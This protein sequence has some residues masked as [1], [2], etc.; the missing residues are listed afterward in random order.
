[1][2]MEIRLDAKVGASIYRYRALFTPEQFTSWQDTF[3]IIICLNLLADIM[4]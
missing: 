1:M 2:I 4:Q 3:R